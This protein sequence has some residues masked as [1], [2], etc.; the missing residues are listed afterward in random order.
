MHDA[1]RYKAGTKKV[2]HY[3]TVVIVDSGPVFK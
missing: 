1:D 3:V 2:Y